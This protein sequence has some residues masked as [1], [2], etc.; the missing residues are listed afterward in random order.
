MRCLADDP[1]SRFDTIDDLNQAFVAATRSRARSHTASVGADTVSDRLKQAVVAGHL[2]PVVYR[3]AAKLVLDDGCG[4]PPLLAAYHDVEDAE[5]I[6]DAM[7]LTLLTIEGQLARANELREQRHRTGVPDL[8]AELAAY[9]E[10]LEWQEAETKAE[11]DRT[12]VAISALRERLEVV[13][14]WFASGG[15]PV[16]SPRTRDLLDEIRKSSME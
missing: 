10:R 14:N 13:V 2:D 6:V 5:F 15:V 16:P 4:S 3:A 1:S 11:R 9:V 8:A 12:R 7:G